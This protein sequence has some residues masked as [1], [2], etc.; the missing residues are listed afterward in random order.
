M[1]ID[2]N[3]TVTSKGFTKHVRFVFIVL[4]DRDVREGGGRSY[5]MR[6]ARVVTV[7]GNQCQKD[8]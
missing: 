1:K 7:T 3:P 6:R 4:P 5:A 2:F 8:R